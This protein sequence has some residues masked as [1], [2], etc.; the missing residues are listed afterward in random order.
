MPSYLINS[1]N[2]RKGLNLRA[3]LS[4]T[5]ITGTSCPDVYVLMF[6]QVS[7]LLERLPT[8]RVLTMKVAYV[9]MHKSDMPNEPILESEDF[10][11]LV[12]SCILLLLVDAFKAL[13]AS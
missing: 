5:P 13:V 3:S 4:S 7:A 2:S 8:P 6:F 11:A 9:L 1:L 12:A 10:V